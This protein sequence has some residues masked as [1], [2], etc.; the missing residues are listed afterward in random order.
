MNVHPLTPIQSEKIQYLFKQPY[1]D[2]ADVVAFAADV[3]LSPSLAFT[4]AVMFSHM[5]SLMK[6]P[7]VVEAV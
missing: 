2:V 4:F 6:I 7:P 1:F 3:A 5:L